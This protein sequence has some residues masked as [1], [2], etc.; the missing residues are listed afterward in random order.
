MRYL[1][2]LLTL[3]RLILG[4]VLLGM[5]FSGGP[6]S[7]AFIVFLVAEL[8]DAFDG[9]CAR[10]WPF[11]KGKEPWYRKYA[12]RYD[13]FADVLLAGAQTL[14]LLFQ[15][16]VAIGMAVVGFYALCA[17]TEL[18]IYGKF[19]GHPD[20]CTPNS[21]I[22]RN[23]PLAKDI[24]ITRRYM[25]TICLGITN[26]FIL[27]AT[28]WPEPVKYLLF[29]FGCAIFVFIWFFLQQRRENISRDATEIEKELAEKTDKK[30]Q[31]NTKKSK[32]TKKT[33]TAQK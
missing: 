11:P 12:A 24:I 31:K 22:K 25:Y 4:L 27:F 3:S 13:M 23:F 1:A 32:K 9:T 21:L 26:A 28:D 19:F 18:I 14:Y 2:D 16:D 17:L 15:V 33:K 8:T 10:K 7:S 30:A 6:A 20:N 29:I 5:S